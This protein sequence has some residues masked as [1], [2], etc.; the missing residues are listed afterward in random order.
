MKELDQEALF[1]NRTKF[2]A[3][4]IRATQQADKRMEVFRKNNWEISEE[5]Q[6]KNSTKHDLFRYYR[7][8]GPAENSQPTVGQL[9]KLLAKSHTWGA[10]LNKLA[11]EEEKR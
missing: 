6:H 4:G 9:V 8:H 5:G 3:S 1:E 2:G 10:N 11:K 7:T